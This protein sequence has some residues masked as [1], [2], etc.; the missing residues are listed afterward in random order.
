MSQKCGWWVHAIPGMSVSLKWN[1]QKRTKFSVQ[2][3]LWGNTMWM[4]QLRWGWWRNCSCHRYSDVVPRDFAS[5][6]CQCINKLIYCNGT[7]YLSSARNV[8]QREHNADVEVVLVWT[9]ETYRF[10]AASTNFEL[11]IQWTQNPSC[12]LSTSTDKLSSD[13]PKPHNFMQ[14]NQ[15]QSKL[16]HKPPIMLGGYSEFNMLVARNAG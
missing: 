16:I 5:D 11:I 12:H 6:D 15:T 9:F 8:W 2:C 3:W 10:L 14:S 1:V 7:R 4:W 13:Q